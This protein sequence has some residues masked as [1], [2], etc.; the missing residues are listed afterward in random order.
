MGR[1]KNM[2]QAVPS[3][4]R[5]VVYFWPWLKPYRRLIAA[6][7]GTLLVGVFLR[8]LEP[9]PLKFILDSVFVTEL[10]GGDANMG[11][12]EELSPYTVAAIAAVAMVVIAALRGLAEYY[13]AIGFARIGNRVLRDVRDHVY[14]HLQGLSL[15]FH[16]KSRSGDLIVRVTRDVSLL[17]DV[18][19]TAVLPM[20]ANSLVLLGMAGVMFWMNWRLAALAMATVPLFWL[21][22]VR[23]G[24]RIRE[25]ARKQREHEGAMAATASES[26][27][28]IKI[29]QALSLE[30]VFAGA[31]ASRN[32]RSQKEDLKAAR[33]S[34]R[35]GRSFD[36]LLAVAQALVLWY[37]ARL[38]LQTELTPGDLIV[39]LTYLKRALYPAR[40]LAKYSARLAKAAAAGE[41]VLDLLD[42]TP[43]IRDRPDAIEAPAFVGHVRFERVTFEYEPGRQVLKEVEFEIAPGQRC[44]LVGPSGI[45]KSTVASLILRLYDPLTGQVMIDGKDI[46]SFTT[47]SLRQQ[48]SVVLQDNLLFASNVWDNIGY[49]AADATRDEIEQT[50]RLANAHE[51]I[52]NLPQGYETVLGERGVTLSHGQRQRIA[53]ARAAIRK[54]PIL[55]LDEPTIG[56]DEENEREV[57][58][59]LERLTV[60]RTTVLITHNLPLASR[61]DKIIFLEGGRIV[62]QG[63]HEELLLAGGRYARWYKL[64]S[65]ELTQQELAS[66]D[67]I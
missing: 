57:M 45:G 11:V 34:A 38:V 51:F 23:L 18:T 9:W 66:A 56:L 48:I 15:S 1:P 5:I 44:A 21:A 24:R 8:L 7:V 58:R 54:A 60:N 3:L 10:S 4:R 39:F 31:F 47:V 32:Q 63:S 41:R 50:A 22:T 29:I 46:R 55:I 36:I 62:E 25:A 6:S 27:T 17:R 16:T 42:R 37:G 67:A 26:I 30:K 14:R 20:L 33:L 52:L 64:H 59:A 61:S 13:E 65:D 19:S 35:L 40:D 53:I 49:G 12:L 28:A 2:Q 43:D